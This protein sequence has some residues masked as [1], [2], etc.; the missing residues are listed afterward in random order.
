MACIKSFIGIFQSQK[1]K[2][3]VMKRTPVVISAV[4]AACLFAACLF[5]PLADAQSLEPGPVSVYTNYLTLKSDLDSLAASYPGHAK[6]FSIGKST[7]GNEMWGIEIG[8]FSDPGYGEMPCFY[9]DGTHHGN[10]QCSTEVTMLTAR[11][12]LENYGKD[13]QATRIVDGRQV[14]IV[15]IINPDGNI[16]DLRYNAQAVDL[17]RNYPHEWGLS[18]SNPG[19]AAGSE[20]ETRANM[21]FMTNRNPDCYLSLHTGSYDLVRPLCDVG[22]EYRGF[23]PEPDAEL[24]DNVCAK[25]EE[26][27]GMGYRGSSGTGES[28]AWAY[29]VKSVFSILMEVSTEQYAPVSVDDV[30]TALW[31]PVKVCLLLAENADRMCGRLSLENIDVAADGK[32]YGASFTVVNDVF[33]TAGGCTLRLAETGEEIYLGNMSAGESATVSFYSPSENPT[34]EMEYSRMRGMITGEEGDVSEIRVS[35]SY[36][37]ASFIGGGA[38]ADAKSADAD[39]ETGIYGWGDLGSSLL[40]AAALFLV[41]TAIALTVQSVRKKK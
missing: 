36:E 14:L 38:H 15:P 5:S 17:N 21:K 27:I 18:A 29:G 25:I 35:D 37:T 3:D 13:G 12:L 39:A 8:N 33:G 34:L 16:L 40:A 4:L 41:I 30:R 6:V 28:I 32:G 2:G 20:A 31:D 11:H 19:S 22:G 26:L 23:R 10:E 7:L 1:E 9:L 24:Y